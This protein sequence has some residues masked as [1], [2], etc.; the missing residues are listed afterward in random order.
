[1][2]RLA[3]DNPFGPSD[4]WYAEETESTMED[5]RHLWMNDRRSGTVVVAGYQRHGRGRDSGRRW[6]S[7]RGESLMLTL[8]IAEE[9]TDGNALSLRVGCAVAAYLRRA[10][11]FA[12]VKWPND[13]LVFGRKICGVLVETAPG[14][15]LIG[16][17][18]NCRQRQFSADI[19]QSAT[20]LRMETDRD[21]PPQAALGPVLSSIRRYLRGEW[22]SRMLP[23]LWKLGDEVSVRAGGAAV[24]GRN[25]GVDASGALLLGTRTGVRRFAGGGIFVY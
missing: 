9:D 4:V 13:V 20:S 7:A 25:L 3:F 22:V 11:V 21:W 16:V 14:G 15:Y 12:S 24:F 5:A 17:G 23:M 10:G 18:L 6:Q 19:R 2:Y 8:A 1:M